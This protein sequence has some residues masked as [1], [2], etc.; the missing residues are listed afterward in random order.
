MCILDGQS[1]PA[2]LFRKD[3]DVDQDAEAAIDVL[4]DSTVLKENKDA[5]V[6]IIDPFVQIAARQMVQELGDTDRAKE[7]ALEIVWDN[8]PNGNHEELSSWQYEERD[9]CEALEPWIDCR[10]RSNQFGQIGSW[11]KGM[12]QRS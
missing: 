9:T 12:Y 5:N 11:W 10:R 6:C 8:Y 7:K 4:V 3:D 1:I 2:L